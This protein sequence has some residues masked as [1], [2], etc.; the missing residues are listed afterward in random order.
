M[1]QVNAHLGTV[2]SFRELLVQ[3]VFAAEGWRALGLQPGDVVALVSRN[4]HE[5]FTAVL[6]AVCAGLSVACITPS[7]TTSR[8]K[9]QSCKASASR[10]RLA[11]ET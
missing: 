9:I 3:T 5:V 2:L 1:P 6:G 4:H 11:H 8:F 10:A 7:A